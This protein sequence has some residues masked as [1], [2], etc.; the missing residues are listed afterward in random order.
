MAT[1]SSIFAKT[2]KGY[3]QRIGNIDVKPLAIRLG[4]VLEGDSLIIPLL[5]RPYHVSR[6]GIIGPSGGE[7][8]MDVCVILAKYILMC[9]ADFPQGRGW[10]SYRDFRDTGPLTTYYE[11]DVQRPI[12]RHFSGR[13][14]ELKAAGRTLG[15]F[16]PASAPAYDAAVQFDALPRIAL[17]LLFND[18]DDEFPAQCKVL[19]QET[20]DQFLDPECMAML[21][22]VLSAR[23]HQV[24]KNKTVHP[25]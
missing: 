23:L 15:G 11:N 25:L 21:A 17:L 10:L 8:A 14:S 3:L 20:A 22:R 16:H 9:P 5:N 7:A 1:E 6:H 18:G 4:A 12:V 19:I 2:V 13:L 24:T